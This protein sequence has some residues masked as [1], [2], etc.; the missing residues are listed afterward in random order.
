MD[1]YATIISAVSQALGISAELLKWPNVTY[2]LVLPFFLFSYA[3]YLILQE[4]KI[5]S[6]SGFNLALGFVISFSSLIMITFL[7]SFYVPFS[8]ILIST[9][10]VRGTWG[11]LI[12]AALAFIYFVFVYPFLVHNFP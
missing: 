1:L 3:I 2:T 7:N 8:L 12:G 10:K 6:S 5:F 11:I 9:F 4:M